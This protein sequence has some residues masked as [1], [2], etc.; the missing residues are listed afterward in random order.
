LDIYRDKI[1][2]IFVAKV[3]H[4]YPLEAAMLCISDP[5]LAKQERGMSVQRPEHD[6]LI[7]GG[8]MGRLVRSIDWSATPL[9]AI[10]TWPQSLRTTVSLCLGSNFPISLAWGPEHI[11]I[12]NDGYWPICGGKHPGSIGQNFRECW[13]SAW[14]AIGDAFER[15]LTGESA[16]LESQRMFLDRHGYL[17]ETFFTFSFSPIRDESGGVGGLFHPVTEMTGKILSE[18]RTRAL[19]DLA[20]RTG[21]AKTIEDVFALAAETLT[22]YDLDLPC[23]LFYVLDADGAQVRLLGGTGLPPGCP[24]R[25]ETIALDAPEASPWP[26]T[27]TLRSRLIQR[28]DDPFA[29]LGPV[30]CGPYPE[31]PK[32]ML[33]LPILPP[34]AD[35][36]MGFV[37]AGVSSR[38]PFDDMYR[39]FLEHMARTVTASVASARAYEE[40]RRRAEALAALDRAKTAF[41]SNISHEFR[42]PLTLM[43]GPVEDA[44]GDTAAR[45]PAAQRQRLEV[46]YRNALRLLKLV[47]T[48]LDFSRVEAGRAQ[49]L[50]EPTDLAAWTADL[51]SHFQSACDQAGLRLVVDCPPLPEPVHVDRDMWEKIVLNLLSNAFKYTLE[52]EIAVQLRTAG[53]WVELTVR[54]TGI[55]IA[56]HELPRLFERFHRVEGARGRT[57]EG[58]GIGLSLVQELVKLHGGTISAE[59]VPGRGSAFTIRIPLGITHLPTDRLCAGRLLA[60]TAVGANAFIEEALRWL[61]EQSSGAAAAPH[62]Q[63]GEGPLVAIDG[64]GAR[65]GR[66]RVL[67]ADDNADMRDYVRRCLEGAGYEVAAVADGQA[68]LVAARTEPAPDLVLTDVMMPNLDGFG[69]LHALRADPRTAGILVILLS[70]RAGEEARV[71]GLAAGA[72]DYLVKP[73]STRELL[74]RLEGTLRLAEARRQA[75]ARASDLRAAVEVER[76]RVALR[77]RNA[78]L[79]LALE[80]GQLGSWD[81]DLD[82]GNAERS[83]Q[84]DQIFG[85]REP[86]PHWTYRTFLDHVVPED[87]GAVDRSFRSAVAAGTSWHR[88]CRIRRADGTIRWIEVHG[89]PV[90][91]GAGQASRLLGIVGDITDRKKHEAALKAARDAAEQAGRAKAR[92]LAAASHDL[93]QPLQG[94]FL[95][96]GGLAA[97]NL[98]PRERKLM[99]NVERALGALKMLL[100]A[101]LDVSKLDSGIVTAERADVAV[102]EVV[103]PILD[104]YKGQA[105][106][107]RLWLRWVPCQAI[108]R[109]DPVLLGRI[110]RNLIENALRYTERGGVLIGCRRR[111]DALLVQV[112]D[113]G[114][115]IS[116]DQ[117][118]EIFEEFVQVGNPARDRA[119]GLGLGLAIVRR[120]SAL[121]DHKVSLRSVPGRGSV[122]SVEVPLTAAAAAKRPAILAGRAH[123]ARGSQRTILVVDDD[124]LVLEA[125]VAVVESWGNQTVAAGSGDEALAKLAA[126][127]APIDAIIADYRLKAGETGLEVIDRVRARSNPRTR[128]ILL[129]GDTAPEIE[130]R[131]HAQGVDLLRKPVLPPELA[132]VLEIDSAAE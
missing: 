22:D 93:R 20:A 30:P 98:G 80:A 65:G 1:I 43:L 54:D 10:E 132:R 44:L 68:A 3:V 64:L 85:Y 57:H 124:E 52:G 73:F 42:T 90:H 5:S 102:G 11:Q 76:G 125:L 86:L 103:G 7:G 37:V 95:F 105:R 109:S 58:T 24:A 23:V 53:K 114:I 49:G 33:V 61:P 82:T 69:L 100:D 112:W 45:L 127:R 75:T 122:F 84:H 104:S 77:D 38:L 101:I 89:S 87:R 71:E 63:G 113:T 17:E 9:G 110:L 25:P 111:R 92:F 40:E 117:Q 46:A 26:L 27:S 19:R 107:K 91:D 47:N 29:R 67:L 16:Y 131:A 8:A 14:P 129:T 88:E 35:R 32:A 36:P 39:A 28:V 66:P 94:L 48:L 99:D 106:D 12:Y 79:H 120:L 21:R 118:A 70:A 6:F 15:A 119:L 34:G 13:A 55:G 74:A 121:L 59:S 130:E 81:L 96:A 123:G 60:S 97:G 56:E 50:F 18:R 31:P 126:V 62:D 72:D 83:L 4:E 115:G 108:V 2:R 41:F 78:R 128:A 116:E 51:A